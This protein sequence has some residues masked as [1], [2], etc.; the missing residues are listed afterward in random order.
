M[1]DSDSVSPLPP[2]LL[3]SQLAALIGGPYCDTDTAGAVGLASESIR[4]LNHAVPRGGVTEP[5]TV[6]AVAADLSIASY[7]LPQLLS[8][9]G[10]WL[11]AESAAGRVADDHHRPPAEL[12]AKVRAAF[13]DAG[14]CAAEL[15]RAL[16]TAHNLSATLHAA[17]PD[18]AAA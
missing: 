17:G 7:R 2:A 16:S 5:A 11:T 15:A 13:G 9:L 8:A 6:S 10:A 12:A 14:A 3:A 4:Y 1:P 18:G